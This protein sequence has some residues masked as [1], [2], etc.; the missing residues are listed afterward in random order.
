MAFN[1]SVI[2]ICWLLTVDSEMDFFLF[3]LLAEG[4]LVFFL[5]LMQF[6]KNDLSNW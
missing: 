2:P 1:F 3:H 4:V 5:K 6:K